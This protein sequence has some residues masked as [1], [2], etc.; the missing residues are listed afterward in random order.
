MS[1]PLPPMPPTF[2]D[3]LV[4]TEHPTFLAAVR[5]AETADRLDAFAVCR[6]VVEDGETGPFGEVF[7]R[8]QRALSFGGA[9]VFVTPAMVRRIADPDGRIA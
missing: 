3:A 6:L 7:W 4:L 1:T 9:D 8:A 5:E 2:E